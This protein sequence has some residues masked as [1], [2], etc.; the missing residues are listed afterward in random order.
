MEFYCAAITENGFFDSFPMV[1]SHERLK[2]LYVI[3]GASGVGKS[4]LMKKV[5]A[6]GERRGLSVDRIYCSSDSNSLDGV[7]VEDIGMID[8]TPP[9]AYDPKMA[10]AFER[11]IDL[12]AFLDASRLEKHRDELFDLLK[13]KSRAFERIYSFASIYGKLSS[14]E[15]SHFIENVDK[16]AVRQYVR[17]LVKRKLS[18][19]KKGKN[20]MR[21]F[22]SLLGDTKIPSYERIY[23]VSD[24]FLFGTVFLDELRNALREAKVEFFFSPKLPSLERIETIY[25][26][27]LKL[28]YTSRFGGRNI[29]GERFLLKDIPSIDLDG[30]KEKTASALLDAH[31]EAMSYHSQIEKIY[32]DMM[33]FCRL[34][35]YSEKLFEELFSSVVE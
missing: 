17:S 19:A 31:R 29:H 33:D 7:I 35:G 32:L 8:G 25:I 1:F 23:T 12:G 5:A 22:S 34:E 6:E 24:R 28:I 27:S 18:F 9:H 2:R 11:L 3:K 26:P 20:E 15:A 14:L 30:L 16:E 4:T 21:I 10:G 13:K